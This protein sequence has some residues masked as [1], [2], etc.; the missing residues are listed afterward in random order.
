M[1]IVEAH[2]TIKHGDPAIARHYAWQLFH[3]G[4]IKEA[5]A[6]AAELGHAAS[7]R[8][9][10]LEVAIAIETGDWEALANPLA[11]FAEEAPK[12]DAATLIR[13]ANLAQASGQGRLGDL[14]DAA[15]AKG[16]DDPNVLVGAYTLVLEDGL[17]ERE[18]EA[19]AWF[20]RALDLSGPDGPIKQFELKDLLSHQTEWSEHSRTIGDAVAGGEM[21]LLVAAPGLRATLADVL[22]GNLVRNAAATDSRKRSPITTFSGR[23]GAP[24][25]IG[26]VRRLALDISAV[27][28]LGWLGLLPSVLDAF[29]EVVVPAGTLYEMFE[30]RARI[31]RFQKSRLRRAEQIRDLIAHK[32]LKVVRSTINPHDAHARDIGAELAGL[33]RLAQANAGIVVRA[34]PVPRFGLEDRRDADVSPYAAVLTDTH[35]LLRVLQELGAVDQATEETARQYFAV[36]DR[37]WTAPQAPRT[38]QPIYLDSLA[39][40]YLHT[41]GLLEA[42]VTSFNDV[43][44]DAGAEEDAFALIEH[45][46]NAAAVLRVIDDARRAILKAHASGKIIFGPRWSQADESVQTLNTPTLHLLGDLCGSDAVVFDDRAL[47]KEPFVT[48]RAGRRA[49]IVT[50]LDIMEEL[51]VRGIFSAA[52]RRMYRHKLRISGC[53]LVPPDVGEVKFAARRTGQHLSP[54]FRAIRDSIDLPRMAE[55]PLFPAEIPWFMTINS[56]AKT[57]LV[58]IWIDESN[59][60][61]AAA[62]ADAVYSIYPNPEDWIACWKGQ[63]PPGW[64]MAVNRI[65]RTTLALPFELG[66]EASRTLVRRLEILAFVVPMSE[67]TEGLASTIQMLKRVQPEL[68]PLLGRALATARL[69]SPR[70]AA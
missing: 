32:R 68:A 49:R 4:R 54:E 24:A 48:D 13:A 8:D 60:D 38:N 29:P 62:A 26:A 7:E 17:D 35:T 12:L 33:I 56:A 36:Q 65:L 14:I 70:A 44:I 1:R 31:R 15:V 58:E 55:I 50:S 23:R 34:A 30:G 11:A 3:R 19:H 57:A 63:P 28:V 66:G 25:P 45:D 37:G 69:G 42:V 10:N 41:V 22:L 47:N 51:H 43:Y 53:C 52:E 61:K 59:I 67:A 18:E 2:P 6:A 21:P 9:L 20:R 39:L 16:G 64:I 40:I 5:A 27:M 46:H